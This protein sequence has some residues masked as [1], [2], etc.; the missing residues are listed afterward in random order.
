MQV[1]PSNEQSTKEF[2]SSVSPKGQITL[3]L[4]LRKKLGVQPK[5]KVTLR[6][7]DDQI[8]VVPARSKVDALY[9]SVPALATPKTLE[10]M[11]KI[12]QEEMAERFAQQNR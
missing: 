12:Y 11:R 6:L 7:E 10:E 4:E 5:D 2:E 8:K 1:V 3:P 9:G